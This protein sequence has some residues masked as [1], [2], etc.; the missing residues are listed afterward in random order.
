MLESEDKKR[1]AS[2]QLANKIGGC[3]KAAIGQKASDIYQTINLP[4]RFED[5]KCLKGYGAERVTH[6]LYKTSSSEYGFLPPSVHSVPLCFYPRSFKFSKTMILGGMY[7]NRSLNT[8]ID[9]S[10]I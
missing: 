6:P 9:K 3:E 7:R 5:P 1:E 10:F 2:C 4:K 8:E